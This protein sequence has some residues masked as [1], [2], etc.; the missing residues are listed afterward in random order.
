VTTDRSRLSYLT[1]R[2]GTY[3]ECHPR[4]Y[5]NGALANRNERAHIDELVRPGELEGVEIYHGLTEMPGQF[6]DMDGCGVILLWTR[7]TA[8]DAPGR[9]FNWKRVGV[10]VGGAALFFLIVK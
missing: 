2:G 1:F 6:A 9:P 7:R 10:F 3:G 5:L 8:S 4:V